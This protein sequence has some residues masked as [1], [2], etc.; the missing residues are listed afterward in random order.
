VRGTREVKEVNAVH[1]VKEKNGGVAAFF[2]LDGTL[3]PLPSLER[4]FFRML[5]CERAIPA[6]NYFLWLRKAMR[7]LPGGIGAMLQ[8]NKMYLR[9]VPV[10]DEC[11]EEDGAVFFWHKDGHQAK[12]PASDLPSK[13]ARRNPRFSVPGFFGQSVDRVAWHAKQGHEIVLVSGTLEPLGRRTA[14]AMEAELAARGITVTIHV[15]A[16]RLEEQDGKWTGRVLG[17]AMFGK[18]KA[19]AA[20]RFA[21]E[22]KIDLRRSYAYGDSLHDRSLM[23]MVG[24]PAAVNPSD[25]LASVARTLGWPVL[26]RDGREIPTQRGRAR[27]GIVERKEQPRRIA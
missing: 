15:I 6:K 5:R 13:S 10:F 16:T 26:H 3:V 21:E 2:D 20:K 8:A 12:R 18:A 22:M 17:E 24:R 9:G 4:R 25:D 14:R 11:D 23:E 1:E 19:R 7:L 27:R